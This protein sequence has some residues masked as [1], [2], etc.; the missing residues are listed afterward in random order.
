[1]AFS[2]LGVR[3]TNS[4]FNLAVSYRCKLSGILLLKSDRISSSLTSKVSTGIDLLGRKKLRFCMNELGWSVNCA[5]E[6]LLWGFLSELYCKMS[7]MPEVSDLT[8][9]ATLSFLTNSSVCV[10]MGTPVGE[11][12][13]K[14][15][16]LLAC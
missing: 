6:T 13:S 11:A 4:A 3:G 9:T 2:T 16:F 15:E 7:C 14:N 12:Y 1:M 5:T 10:R 8:C